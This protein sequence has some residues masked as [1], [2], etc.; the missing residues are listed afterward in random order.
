MVDRRWQNFARRPLSCVCKTWAG[1]IVN[2]SHHWEENCT[3]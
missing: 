1:S 2:R 3:L